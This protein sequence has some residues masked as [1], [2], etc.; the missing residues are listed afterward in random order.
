MLA[1]SPVMVTKVSRGID[2]VDAVPAWGSTWMILMVS[3]RWP[4]ASL[5][6]TELLGLGRRLAGPAVRADQ[7]D[8]VGRPVG[9]GHTLGHGAEAIW[10]HW[11]R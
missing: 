7:Q 4:P 3:D 5:E 1:G 9:R 2:R 11:Y 8:V 10:P 6:P